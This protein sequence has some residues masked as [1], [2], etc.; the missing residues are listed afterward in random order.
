MHVLIIGAGTGGLALAQRLRSAGVQVSVHERDRT[1]TDGLFGYRVGISPDGSRALKACLPPA[2]FDTFKKTV[3]ISPQYTNFI[4]ERMG[5]LFVA[6]GPEDEKVLAPADPEFAERSVSRM[7]LRQIELTGLEDVVHFDRKF[8]RYTQNPDGTVTAHFA[9]GTSATGDLLVGADGTS[10][11]V[12]RQFLPDAKLVETDLFGITGK[13]PLTDEAR[14]LLTPKMLR[15]VTMVFAP[16]GIN[17]IFHV[18]EFEWQRGDTDPELVRAWPGLTFDNTRD[19]VMWGSARTGGCS[20][21]TSW[22][23]P[24]PSCTGWC[25]TGRGT[26]RRT[27]GGCSNWPTP[28]RASRSTSAPRNRSTRGRA[29][30]SR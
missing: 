29:R 18:M 26:G 7:T 30:T 11:R 6:G 20:R 12:R 24:G 25:S 22:T 28:R 3:A 13:L 4:T 14:S 2:L 23:C 27:C 15:G 8:E 5:E 9:D 17:T 16:H 19:Y 1:R 21:T 10:S